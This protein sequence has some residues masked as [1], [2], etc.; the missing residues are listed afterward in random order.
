MDVSAEARTEAAEFADT[1]ALLG[2][3]VD[4]ETPLA[5]L[6][7]SIMA[8]LASTPQVER[9]PDAR[10]SGRAESIAQARW[11]SRPVRA[12]LAVAAAVALIVGGGIAVTTINATT[13]QQASADRLAA[14]YA[15]SDMTSIKTTM[16]GG[17]E[18]TLVYA[19]SLATAALIVDGMHSLP[20]DKVYELWYINDDGARPAGMLNVGADGTTWC[21]L[22]GTMLHGDSVGVTVEPRGGSTT[23]SAD[24]VL[25]IASA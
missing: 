17:G 22:E 1:A 3:A 24:P 13:S 10:F 2:L 6:K 11:F 9:E 23:P 18:A 5:T 4:P 21:V 7:A 15:A 19:S 25:M 14:I 8:Q 20:P 16:E 12:L